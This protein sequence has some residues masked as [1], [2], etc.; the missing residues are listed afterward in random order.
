MTFSNLVDTTTVELVS[1]TARHGAKIVLFELAGRWAMRMARLIPSMSNLDLARPDPQCR[2]FS[3]SP[4]RITVHSR[5][6]RSSRFIDLRSLVLLRE[7]ISDRVELGIGGGIGA[8]YSRRTAGQENQ[9]WPFD[10]LCADYALDFTDESN[11]SLCAIMKTV[12]EAIMKIL[13]EKG[14]GTHGNG[15]F[16]GRSE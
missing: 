1:L 10:R 16:Q 13:K 9:L 4:L 15:R 2:L 14:T 11:A 5:V 3:G 7:V 12:S 6:A 8:T